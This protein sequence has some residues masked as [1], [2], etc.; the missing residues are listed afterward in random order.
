MEPID[1]LPV[2]IEGLHRGLFVVAG[3]VADCERALRRAADEL[4]ALGSRLGDL[5]A[6]QREMASSVVGR[7]SFK[8]ELASVTN[9]MRGRG[10]KLTA[11]TEMLDQIA[12]ELEELRVRSAAEIG[13]IRA[14]QLVPTTEVPDEV[15]DRVATV[16]AALVTVE[17]HQSGQQSALWSMQ[18]RIDELTARLAAVEAIPGEVGDLR[19]LLAEMRLEVEAAR[20]GALAATTEQLGALGRLRSLESIP[21]DLEDLYRELE[22]VAEMAKGASVSGLEQLND[23]LA[24]LEAEITDIRS[25]LGLVARNVEIGVEAVSVSARRDGEVFD[26]RLRTLESGASELQRLAVAL[27]AHGDSSLAGQV[28][29]AEKVGAVA[30]RL[31][32]LDGLP[33]DVEALYR[34]LD[35]IVEGVNVRHAEVLAAL[36]KPTVARLDQIQGQV[37]VLASDLDRAGDHIITLLDGDVVTRSSLAELTDRIDGPV[38]SLVGAIR[39]ELEVLSR[40]T[41]RRLVGLEA[42]VPEVAELAQTVARA[43][44]VATEASTTAGQVG[45]SQ[46]DKVAVL[47]ASVAGLTETVTGLVDTVEPLEVRLGEIAEVVS[48]CATTM[49]D[50]RGRIDQL[51]EASGGAASAVDELRNRIDQLRGWCSTDAASLDELAHRVAD[52]LAQSLSW[53]EELRIA[54]QRLDA[55][56]GLPANVAS[57]GRLLARAAAAGVLDGG[58]LSSVEDRLGEAVA[59]AMQRGTAAVSSIEAVRSEMDHIHQDLEAFRTDVLAAF[60]AVQVVDDD[61]QPLTLADAVAALQH[62]LERLEDQSRA[63]R[64]AMCLTA[65]GLDSLQE[66]TIALERLPGELRGLD[67]ML[68]RLDYQV[69]AAQREALN[70]VGTKL[71]ELEAQV[72]ALDTLRADVEGLYGALYRVADGAGAP[73]AYNQEDEDE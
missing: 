62:Q 69:V 13:A 57:M 68:T 50:I 3:G 31:G 2:N 4:I 41:E 27:K 20:Q 14:R 38:R 47:T 39:S 34:E 22:R 15:F 18:S 53:P 28:E 35:G 70:T 11:A 42:L 67:E 36:V 49:E 66:R 43:V 16:E 30:S 10:Q 21:S 44:D 9:E 65:Q 58:L 71:A 51:A 12:E 72:G 54:N 24:P 37:E 52:G 61:S 26:L 32:Q 40:G 33:G 45:S 1:G 60:Q 59:E 46:S 56:E 55:L 5:E 64:D 7:D 19:R 23:R 8:R 17:N 25:G 73:D 6:R 48:P 63:G 29:L